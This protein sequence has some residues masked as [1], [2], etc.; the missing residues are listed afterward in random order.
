MRR[1][2]F[3]PTRDK[4]TGEWRRLHNGELHDRCS[5]PNISRNIKSRRMRGE[6]H[7]VSMGM[8]RVAQRALVE[9]PEGNNHLQDPGVDWRIILRW[10]FRKWDWG[11]ALD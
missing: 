5:A 3:W 9:K 6:E 1:R 2:I 10:I 8:R 7:V 11:H 4:V